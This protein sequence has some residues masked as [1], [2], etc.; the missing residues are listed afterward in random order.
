M[1]TTTLRKILDLKVWQACTPCPGVVQIAAIGGSLGPDQLVYALP[2]NTT[3]LYCYDPAEDSWTTLATP[4]LGSATAGLATCWHPAGPTGTASAG[5]STTITTATTVSSDLSARSGLY[6]R[7]RITGGTGAGQE[8]LIS[9]ATMGANSVITVSSAWLANPDA[10]STYQLMTG[11]LWMFGGGTL[12]TGSLKYFD[13]ATASYSGSLSTSGLPGTF[14]TDGRLTG[15]PSLP[16]FMDAAVAKGFATGTATSGGATGLTDSGQSW[17]A[18]QWVNSQVR[19]TGG[20]GAGQVRTI[21]ANTGTALTVATWGTNPDATSTY[22]IEGNDD[23]LYL[24]GN[25]AIALYKYSISG[26]SWAALSPGVPRVGA[27]GAGSNFDWIYGVTQADW[28]AVG[29]IRN[30]SRLYSFRS[31]AT[32]DYYDIAANSW[33]N[34]VAIYRTSENLSANVDCIYDSGNY[35]YVYIYNSSVTPQRFVRL[36][37]RSGSVEPFAT[38]Q[39]PCVGS[40]AYAGNKI[41][42]SQYGDTT[43]TPLRFLY[44]PQPGASAPSPVHRCLIF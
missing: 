40:A 27:P 34:G 31:G 36:D 24:M 37:L 11:R 43:G 14:G 41:W 1:P 28:T 10:T 23:N 38:N 22:S 44:H 39:Y 2:N 17:T 4:A 30:G 9:S 6:F 8:R 12:A 32:L 26:N 25:G 19:I 33:T 29:A 35:L 13:Y 21:T 16:G 7:I 3:L 42:I 5:S 20:T 18:S 15:T